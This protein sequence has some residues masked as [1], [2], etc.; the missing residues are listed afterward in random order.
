MIERD[1]EKVKRTVA[2][3]IA[4]YRK[5]CNL[6][7]DELAEM[8]FY[9]GKSVSKWERGDGLPDVC[10]LVALAN[11]F[12]VTPNDMLSEKHKIAH[13]A[14]PQLKRNIITL[15]SLSLVWLIAT[16]V[17]VFI[18]LGSPQAERPWLAFIIAIPVMFIVAIVLTSLWHPKPLVFLC[19][20]A[21][22]WSLAAAIHLCFPIE[23]MFLVYV[24][25]AVLQ[26]LIILWYL[27]VNTNLLS[28]FGKLKKR[29][30]DKAGEPAQDIPPKSD[31]S[32]E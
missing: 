13:H 30:A 2:S 17:Y 14:Q 32:I 10:V 24:I 25:A 20:S 12:G 8:I 21:L 15:M 5:E 9:S 26:L 16:M 6:T 4:H 18:R 29:S 1:D 28:G 22:V 31:E 23:G 19:I 7:Q 3:N 27:L 11:I